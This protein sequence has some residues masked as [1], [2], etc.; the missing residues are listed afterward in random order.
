ML[1]IGKRKWRINV[2]ASQLKNDGGADVFRDRLQSPEGEFSLTPEAGDYF[3]ELKIKDGDIFILTGVAKSGKGD[4]AQISHLAI[5]RGVITDYSYSAVTGN[6][7]VKFKNLKK[8]EGPQ[9]ERA[10]ENPLGRG[11]VHS[12]EARDWKRFDR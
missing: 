5:A 4:A 12:L 6:A 9:K 1:T 8:L 2:S 7:R 10:M 3:A 11:N